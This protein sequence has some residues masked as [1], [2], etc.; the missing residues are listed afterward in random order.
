MSQ[1]IFGVPFT[2]ATRVA[3]V[4]AVLGGFFSIF[5]EA[6]AA[7][8]QWLFRR[9]DERRARRALY[10]RLSQHY[11]QMGVGAWKALAAWKNATGDIAG[12][13]AATGVEAIGVR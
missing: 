3:V 9:G 1:G 11:F 7:G 10:G 2:D 13:A 12:F 8:L 5:K 6:F 4:G